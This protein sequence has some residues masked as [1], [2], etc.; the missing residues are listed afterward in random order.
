MRFLS[1]KG[2]GVTYSCPATDKEA[3]EAVIKAV[4]ACNMHV[5]LSGKTQEIEMEL[6]DQENDRLWRFKVEVDRISELYDV[7][8]RG[9]VPKEV[10]PILEQ[11]RPE[12]RAEEKPRQEGMSWV[13]AGIRENG[14]LMG[15]VT[16][17]IVPVTSGIVK[18]SFAFCRS[19]DCF[20]KRLGRIISRE[21]MDAGTFV[22]LACS[23]CRFDA[24][25]YFLK[26]VAVG[27]RPKN[28]V[29]SEIP[30]AYFPYWLDPGR[31]KRG[32]IPHDVVVL[33][34]GIKSLPRLDALTR[35]QIRQIM[36]KRR[37][38]DYE[39]WAINDMH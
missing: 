10:R 12:E 36:N 23:K 21:R 11:I 37:V 39:I 33:L 22:K 24:V 8:H 27:D 31:E 19:D 25:R 38:P 15:W 1:I 32:D 17:C 9:T 26:A 14:T 18:A 29:D 34:E 30:T 13:H 16:A 4:A 7:F 28:M 35:L 3:R 5:E 20:S 6:Q 2:P